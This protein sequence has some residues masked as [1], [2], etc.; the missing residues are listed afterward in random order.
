MSNNDKELTI[1]KCPLCGQAHTYNLV[2]DK[3]TTVL[4]RRRNPQQPR[5]IT[6]IFTCP[7]KQEN[8]QAT[9]EE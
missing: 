6:R 8:F 3:K 9:Y 5:L 1:D 2:E 4:F 7:V